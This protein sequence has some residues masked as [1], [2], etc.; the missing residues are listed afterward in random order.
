MNT[1]INKLIREG[2][3]EISQET[4]FYLEFCQKTF[5]RIEWAL[6]RDLPLEVIESIG[7]I[8][9]NLQLIKYGLSH[10]LE[11]LD[12]TSKLLKR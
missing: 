4:L 12:E 7:H 5:A 10:E 1:E 2:K 6:Y 8:E 9:S 11:R 3:R